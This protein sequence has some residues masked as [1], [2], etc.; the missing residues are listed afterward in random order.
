MLR[1]SLFPSAHA[2]PLLSDGA[3]EASTHSRVCF[4]LTCPRHGRVPQSLLRLI[5]YLWVDQRRHRRHS[6]CTSDLA[7][8][9]WGSVQLMPQLR[10]TQL[11]MH[12]RRA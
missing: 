1:R 7:A 4:A 11:S 2:S 8:R 9:P 12:G 6:G 10:E 5:N 3:A